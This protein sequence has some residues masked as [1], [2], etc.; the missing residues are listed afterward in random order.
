MAMLRYLVL[1][2]GGVP[3]PTREVLRQAEPDPERR[4]HVHVG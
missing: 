2:G 3:P 1:G 4:P